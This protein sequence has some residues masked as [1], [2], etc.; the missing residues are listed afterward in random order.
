MVAKLLRNMVRDVA[1]S[2]FTAVQQ[3]QPEEQCYV[4]ALQSL[5][6]ATGVYAHANT[7][8]GYQL[9][10]ARKRS[11][12]WPVDERTC[13]WYWGEWAHKNIRRDLFRGVYDFINRENKNF[14]Q[15]DLWFGFKAAVF[16]S[17]ALALQ[18]LDGEGLFGSGEVRERITLLC[19]VE[20]SFCREWVEE[21]SVQLLNPP[22]LYQAFAG[23]SGGVRKRHL[24]P[25]D[26][27]MRDEFVRI[28]NE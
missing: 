10:L 20:D 3:E 11:N 18:D 27:R 15:D 28:L 24:H 19:T 6:D 21:E 22:V 12:S 13:R 5:D 23:S 1:R 25:D 2:A 17:M 4:F 9:T 16:A 8:E 26:Q 14:Q 7:E